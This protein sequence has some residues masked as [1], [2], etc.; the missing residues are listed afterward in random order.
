MAFIGIPCV[1]FLG[2]GYHGECSRRGLSFTIRSSVHVGFVRMAHIADSTH[3]EMEHLPYGQSIAGPEFPLVFMPFI[4]HQNEVM[5]REFDPVED[6]PVDGDLIFQSSTKKSARI[7]SW[8]YRTKEFRKIRSTYIDAG[9]A[10]QVFNSV[11]Y[12][13]PEYDLPLLGID[14]LSFGKKRVLCVLDFQPLRQDPGY[15]KRYVDDLAGIKEKYPGLAGQM[16]ARFYDENKFFSK[17]L[18]FGR[19]ED[20]DPIMKEL[21]PAYKEYLQHYIQLIKSTPP[22]KDPAFVRDVHRLQAEYDQYSAE[23]DPA[24]GLFSTYFGQE[25]AEKFTHE[26]LFEHST[27]VNKPAE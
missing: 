4:T 19:F 18:A 25:W 21:F 13:E 6:V 12:P 20:T 11:W 27:P 17:Q 15:M 26:F 3:R 1:S 23:R 24:V 10:A 9:L 2:T 16:T 22:N 8:C 7:E 5:R 14:F